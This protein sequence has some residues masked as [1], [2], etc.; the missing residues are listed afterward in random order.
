M[1][2][3]VRGT[4]TS[5]ENG[6]QLCWMEH[7]S[8]NLYWWLPYMNILLITQRLVE[9]VNTT[10]SHSQWRFLNSAVK[11]LT[12]SEFFTNESFYAVKPIKKSFFRNWITCLTDNASLN[13][14]STYIH[15]LQITSSVSAL[16]QQRNYKVTL[17]LSMFHYPFYH[18]GKRKRGRRKHTLLLRFKNLMLCRLLLL[19]LFW[20]CIIF[21]CF[22]TYPH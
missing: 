8:E 17:P 7:P 18:K 1:D 21:F 5:I 10:G 6:K 19:L 20:L 15:R 2:R 13:T 16:E 11:I 4:V 3:T 9:S 12:F 14:Q 22:V